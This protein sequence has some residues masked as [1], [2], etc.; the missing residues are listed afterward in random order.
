MTVLNIQPDATAGKDNRLYEQVPDNN[1]GVTVNFLTG[2]DAAGLESRGLIQFDL[3]SIPAN[4]VI[5][6][7]KLYLVLDSDVDT[8]GARTIDIHRVTRTWG[9]GTKSNDTATTGESSWNSSAVPTTWTAA[10]GD[11]DAT[12]D[13]SA[14]VN[15]TGSCEFTITDLVKEWRAG[16]AN[17]GILIKD[18]TTGTT[19]TRKR[20]ETSDSTTAGNRPNLEITYTLAGGFF[21][22]M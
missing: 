12:P 14:S 22:F 6:S 20:F 18:H 4:A 16:T 5:S 1:F 7:A 19:S 11:Y 13:G 17:Y 2:E 21:A 10:G 3:S 15:G 8:A 9:E